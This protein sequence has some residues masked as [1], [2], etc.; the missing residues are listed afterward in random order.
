MK[1]TRKTLIMKSPEEYRIGNNELSPEVD[2]QSKF[3]SP[4]VDVK[5]Y[6]V[7]PKV[8]SL[9]AS[10]V[11]KSDSKFKCAAVEKDCILKVKSS[12][13]GSKVKQIYPEVVTDSESVSISTHKHILHVVDTEVVDAWSV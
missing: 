8:D 4:D 12:D 5:F 11:S 7:S 3:T 13:T 1:P 2:G 9:G 10:K 6:V